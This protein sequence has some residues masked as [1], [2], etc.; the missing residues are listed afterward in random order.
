MLEQATPIRI[1]MF[2]SDEVGKDFALICAD[3]SQQN[4]SEASHSNAKFKKILNL[5]QSEANF[6][7]QDG[8]SFRAFTNNENNNK[9][10]W[11]KL[12]DSLLYTRTC[13]CSVRF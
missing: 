11:G 5:M 9:S 10:L 8:F 7:I 3:A 4:V 13:Q 2:P 12:A 6:N 1:K